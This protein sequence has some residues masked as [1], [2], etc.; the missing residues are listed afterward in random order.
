[1]DRE[2]SVVGEARGSLRAVGA[3][4]YLAGL[5]QRSRSLRRPDWTV[6]SSDRRRSKVGTAEDAR[7]HRSIAGVAGHRPGVGGDDRGGTR[8]GLAFHPGTA[9]QSSGAMYLNTRKSTGWG[10]QKIKADNLRDG[11]LLR[12]I[13]LSG[14]K[15]HYSL[16]RSAII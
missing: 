8:R 11:V 5:H 7:R 4:S 16:N 9:I 14:H 12:E 6:G 3:R 10:L 13:H 1:M 2:V 15:F